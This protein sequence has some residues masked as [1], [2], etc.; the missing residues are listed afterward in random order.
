MK[1][2]GAR[3]RIFIVCCFIL[4]FIFGGALS[5]QTVFAGVGNAWLSIGMQLQN[6]ERI[7]SPN[8]AYEAI[9][10]DDGNLVVY[11]I[12]SGGL[13]PVWATMSI[14]QGYNSYNTVVQADGNLVVY[15]D[16]NPVWNAGTCGSSGSTFFLKMQDDGNLVLYND[17]SMWLWCSNYGKN[18][19]PSPTQS[20]IQVGEYLCVGQRI[21]SP[22]GAYEAIQQSDGRLVVL[23]YTSGWYY[24]NWESFSDRRGYGGF[25]TEVQPDG[26]LVI[27]QY[28][29][30]IWNTE[31]C[32]YPGNSFV[33]KM[34]DD[35]NLVLYNEA[36]LWLWCSRLDINTSIII[37]IKIQSWDLVDSGKHLDYDGNSKYMDKI[38]TGVAKW[39]NYKGGVIRK[40]NLF[41]TRDL[42]V[43]D[44][45]SERS[46]VVAS[47]YST[48]AIYISE[49]EMNNLGDLQQLNVTIH[50]LGHALGL[51]HNTKVDI[52]Y[53]NVTYI[54]DISV[55]DKA[56]YDAAYN[57]Y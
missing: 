3:E 2:K 5:N 12:T 1:S 8:G 27:Y 46:G 36:G 13:N 28:G 15:G 33:L 57:N 20:Q 49:S 21:V 26:N 51:D 44:K 10:Q 9:Q 32:G 41:N 45:P 16:G 56:S 48:G 42:Y 25:S 24:L 7:V 37:T 53:K 47:T 34:Q 14:G 54:T 40:D 50:E 35:G 18:P 55:N 29:N 30:A 4:L 22:N 6:G 38:E 39:N 52:M 19:N 43:E 11:N 17:S 31:T 23:N